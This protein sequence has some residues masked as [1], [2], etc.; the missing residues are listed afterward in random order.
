MTGIAREEGGFVARGGG[1]N[2]SAE[3]MLAESG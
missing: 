1:R 3:E 2:E